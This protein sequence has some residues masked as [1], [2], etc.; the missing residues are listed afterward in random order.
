LVFTYALNSATGRGE[1]ARGAMETILIEWA[2][3]LLRWLHMIAGMA[4]IGSSF[5]FMHIDAAMKPVADIAKGGEAWEVHGGGFY[6]VRKW[7]VAPDRLPPELI[8]HKWEAYTTWVSGFFLLM[9]IYY[10][11]ADLYLIDPAVRTLSPLV[12][13]AI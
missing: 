7:L 5:Y 12:A 8:W 10:L 2:S 6:Q 11:G 4:W 3:L 13:G 1:T 9:T